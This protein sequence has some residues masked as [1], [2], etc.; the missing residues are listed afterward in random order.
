MTRNKTRRATRPTSAHV[1]LA[2][3]AALAEHHAGRAGQ[4][5]VFSFGDPVEVLDRRELLDYVECMRMGQWYEPPLPWDG[6][7]R[8]FRA[9]AHHSSAVY[10]KR[11]ILVSTFIPHPLLSRA[12]FERLV[13]DWQVFGNAY[14]ERRD[15]VLRQPMRLEAPLA[16]YVRRGI[17]L[18][19]YFSCRTGSSHT[20]FRP[21]RCSTCRNRTSTRRCTACRNTCPR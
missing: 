17:D 16:K 3:S 11:N 19:T 20:L 13:L 2:T 4:V 1:H 10:V 8:S 21:A 6:L 14:L 9:A 7:A 15:N 18:S 5:E 12:T